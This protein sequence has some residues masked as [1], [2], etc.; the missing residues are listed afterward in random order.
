MNSAR[1]K[2][3]FLVPYPLRRAPSQRFRVEPY[4]P[5]FASHQLE[6]DIEPFFDEKCFE[7]LYA[8]GNLLKKAAGVFKGFFRRFAT[9][10]FRLHRYDYIFIHREAAPVGPPFFE[11]LITKLFRKKYIFDFDDAIWIPDGNRALVNWVRGYWK[12]KYL[13]QWAYKVAGGNDYLCN[14]AKKYQKNVVLLPTSVD[15]EH[16]HNRTKDQNT[17][18]VVIG[19]TGSHSTLKYLDNLLPVLR[20]LSEQT[21]VEVL[22]ICNQKPDFNLKNFRFLSWSE[23]TEVED[24]LRINIGIMPLVNDAWSEGK[25]GFKL[26]QYL[27]LGIP[28]VA[29]PVGVNKKIIDQG[30]NG[31]LCTTDQ[32]WQEALLFLIS[33]E[34][35]RRRMGAEGQ[36]KVREEF[37]IQVNEGRFFSLFT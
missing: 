33:D 28:A 20:Q 6:Y 17:Q 25:C 23:K 30:V 19:W 3:L 26:I 34:K 15:V 22:V 8:K 37:S 2:I 12:T 9:V 18:A 14:Y 1:K 13:C 7:I 10:L 29:S 4:L 24:L 5:L 32:E 31:F 27:S 21:A 16:H 35:V 36:K 11:W